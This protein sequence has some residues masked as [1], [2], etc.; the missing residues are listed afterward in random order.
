MDCAHVNIYLRKNPVPACHIN[1][2][3]FNLPIGHWRML[4]DWVSTSDA[5]QLFPPNARSGNLSKSKQ[6]HY[7]WDEYFKVKS[8][9]SSNWEHVLCHTMLSNRKLMKFQHPCSVKAS[10]KVNP[11]VFF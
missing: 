1:S 4:H 5:E 8:S 2:E 9:C 10:Q 11:A 6:L 3:M 7:G